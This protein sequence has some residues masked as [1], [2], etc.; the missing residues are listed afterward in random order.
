MLS[1]Y[2]VLKSKPTAGAS[3]LGPSSYFDHSYGIVYQLQLEYFVA[4]NST[5]INITLCNA[6]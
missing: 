1:F 3:T 5:I 6:F 4:E 2:T